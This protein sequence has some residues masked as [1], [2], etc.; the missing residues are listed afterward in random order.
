MLQY[1]RDWSQISC[2]IISLLVLFIYHLLY[3]STR[4]QTTSDIKLDVYYHLSQRLERWIGLYLC[5]NLLFNM[6]LRKYLWHIASRIAD[7]F[8]IKGESQPLQLSV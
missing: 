5:V 1:A 6:Y 8:L 7:T 3:I 2:Q 4:A